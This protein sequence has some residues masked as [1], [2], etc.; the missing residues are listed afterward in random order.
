MSQAKDKELGGDFVRLLAGILKE[1]ELT[2]IEYETET[3]RIKVSRE[4][5]VVNAPFVSHMNVPSHVEHSAPAVASDLKTVDVL[6][7]AN[8]LKSPIV[9][10]AYRASSPGA[11]FF[12]EVGQTIKEGDTLLI[13]EAMKV[14]NPIKAP[15]SG[16]I[17]Q[18]LVE[19]N[20]PVEY[21][22]ILMVIE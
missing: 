17:K 2:E 3:A 14:M 10:T 7:T 15:K 19:D 6:N 4:Q 22:E 5:K 20:S 13:I 21:G 1:S 12:V 11:P 18:I 8:A 9:G 16:V